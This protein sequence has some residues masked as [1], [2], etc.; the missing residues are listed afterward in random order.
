MNLQQLRDYDCWV[1]KSAQ[2]VY[3][4][5]VQVGGWR[6]VWPDRVPRWASRIR[7]YFNLSPCTLERITG[8][9]AS[10]ALKSTERFKFQLECHETQTFNKYHRNYRPGPNGKLDPPPFTVPAA[11]PTTASHDVKHTSALDS[12][13]AKSALEGVVYK[14]EKGL[15]W[16]Q[17]SAGATIY[18]WG[19]DVT[20]WPEAM[21]DAVYVEARGQDFA[22]IFKLISPDNTG[23]SLECIIWNPRKQHTI[24]AAGTTLNVTKLINKDPVHQ[25]SYNYS[26]TAHMGLAAHELRDVKTHVAKTDFY[27][28]PVN[29][30][31]LLA[32]RT[33]P[34]GGR[35]GAGGKSLSDEV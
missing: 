15:L 1:G 29:C 14:D 28:N 18:N 5:S 34:A 19:S 2:T 32:T 22:P 9:A 25:G 27:I 6:S 13:A 11:C 24:V 33:F 35:L 12:I 16:Y 8:K 17:M 31:S 4:S 7:N 20:S 10:S 30:F 23:G 21:V 3:V 26:E